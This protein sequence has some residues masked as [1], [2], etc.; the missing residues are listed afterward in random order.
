MGEK[1]NVAAGVGS[2]SLAKLPFG[3]APGGSY[4]EN[5]LSKDPAEAFGKSPE[6]GF[7]KNADEGWGKHTDGT[8]PQPNPSGLAKP[9]GAVPPPAW[10]TPVQRGSVPLPPPPPPGLPLAGGVWHRNDRRD[11]TPPAPPPA[12]GPQR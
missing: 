11:D 6:E 7:V 4:A 9:S 12:A 2:S 1:G 8:A 5:A 10:Q 3:H